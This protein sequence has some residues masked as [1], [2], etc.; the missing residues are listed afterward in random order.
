MQIIAVA[1]IMQIV[2][3]KFMPSSINHHVKNA[4]DIIPSENPINLPG[5]INPS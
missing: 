3:L 2:V 5:H 4:K 1:K